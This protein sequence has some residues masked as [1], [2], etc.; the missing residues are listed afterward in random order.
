MLTPWVYFGWHQIRLDVTH[1]H[2]EGLGCFHHQFR[3]SRSQQA[4]QTTFCASQTS[5]STPLRDPYLFP[6]RKG[7]STLWHCSYCAPSQSCSRKL[8]SESLPG[9]LCCRC[10]GTEAD[11]NHGS[12]SGLTGK[13]RG[14]ASSTGSVPIV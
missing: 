10:S 6:Y 1:G 12:S 9:V 11:L 4:K 7:C 13:L 5:A 2:P 14:W 3:D 8:R